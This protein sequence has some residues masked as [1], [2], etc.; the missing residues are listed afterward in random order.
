MASDPQSAFWEDLPGMHCEL[1]EHQLNVVRLY[2]EGAMIQ[3]IADGLGRGRKA[4]GNTLARAREHIFGRT[5]IFRSNGAL[6]SWYVAHRV[7]CGREN[8]TKR[9]AARSI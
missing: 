6:G 7:C 3:E 8:G 4:I 5:G 1:T 2:S 9:N